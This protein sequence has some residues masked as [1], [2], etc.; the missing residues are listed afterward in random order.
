MHARG[1]YSGAGSVTLMAEFAPFAAA[2]A[3]HRIVLHELRYSADYI[4][5]SLVRWRFGTGEVLA[6]YAWLLSALIYRL[7]SV[8]V[9]RNNALSSLLVRVH[10]PHSLRCL[11]TILL[12]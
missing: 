2:W 7:F 8:D 6:I 3:H 11:L 12:G 5:N 4:Q 9:L 10:R 1:G